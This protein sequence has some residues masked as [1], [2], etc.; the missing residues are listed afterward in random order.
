MKLS[1]SLL[2]ALL[3]AGTA[4]ATPAFVYSPYKLLDMYRDPSHAITIEQGG[5]RVAYLAGQRSTLTWAFATGECGAE[6]WNQETAADV[7]AANVAA[8]EKAGVDYIISTG[9]QGAMFTCA[10]DAGMERFIARYNSKR[11][12]GIDFDIE[13]GQTAEQIESLVQRARNAQRKH[14]KLRFSFTVATHAASDGSR[15]SLNALGETI[16]AAVRR[17]GLQDYTFNLMVMDYGT[18][19]PKHCV[20][21]EGVCDMAASAVQ[22]VR[23]VHEKHGIPLQ[24]IEVTPMIGANDVPA[25]DFTLKDAEALVRAVREMKLA[26]LHFWSI[27]RDKPCTEAVTGAVGTCGGLPVG[28]GAYRKVFEQLRR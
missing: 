8:F 12:V 4:H 3:C 6:V 26:G 13:A 28:E 1:K 9:G 11:L 10:T 7:A 20:V 17:S 2:C 19:E 15:Q 23:N 5:Q 18:P 22:A 25:N 14:K 24:Q 27:D 21:R 16:L